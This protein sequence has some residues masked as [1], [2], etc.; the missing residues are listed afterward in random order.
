MRLGQPGR[1]RASLAEAFRAVRAQTE[2]LCEP[3]ETEDYVI[4]SMPDVSP[5]EVAPGAHDA[6]SSRTSCSRSCSRAT[7]PS[8]RCSP[9]SSTPT[10]TWPASFTRRASAACS[11]GPRV[12]EVYALP[13]PRHGRD[14]AP[15]RRRRRRA[16]GAQSR[17]R[18][19]SA[20]NH[21][22]QHQELLLTDI[23]H[24]FSCNPLRARLPPSAPSS[25][26][27]R[28]RGRCGWAR[29]RGRRAR[30]RASTGD[31]F[32]F[33][34]ESPRHR[35]S[36]RLPHRRPPGDQRRVPARSSTTAA[37]SAPSSGSPTAGRRCNEQGWQR[38]AVL[39]A[40]RRRVVATS[41]SP[42]MRR[43]DPNEPVCHV[44]HYEADA[45]ARWAGKRLP[46]EA[47]WEHAAAIDAGRG[48][49][50]RKRTAPPGAAG[51]RTRSQLF[52]DVWEWTQSA[53][54]PYPGFQPLPRR[55]RRVQRQVHVQPDGAARRL[56]RDAGVAHPRRPTAT[57]S[58]R[59]TRWQ[60]TG[61]RLAE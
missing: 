30:D 24:I 19:S 17:R 61:L 29:V 58:S 43:V 2:T 27:A 13:R 28:R 4:Q 31:G 21:E 40:A 35:S 3:L 34:N 50:R 60:F 33:D 52:G 38:A 20:C 18:S 54:L 46:T 14:A 22:Q 42:A 48:Q 8:T 47:E 9:T 32:A 39:G 59:T 1:D 57:S 56:L 23:K 53:Y 12:A 10:T 37:T 44:S 36:S 55:G 6:G 41:P 51:Q 49:L 5:T 45:Y 25:A 15:A 7:R 26:V 11:P 16:A